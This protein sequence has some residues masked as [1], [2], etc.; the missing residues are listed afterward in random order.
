MDTQP[1]PDQIQK[2]LLKLHQRMQEIMRTA[3]EARGLS[4]AEYAVDYENGYIVSI[5][6][7][8][9]K[10]EQPLIDENTEQ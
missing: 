8:T 10:S 4:S 1:L 5:E 7:D 2:R 9:S 6:Q 3:F